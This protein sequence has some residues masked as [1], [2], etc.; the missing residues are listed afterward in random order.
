[1]PEIGAGTVAEAIPARW[2]QGRGPD[3]ESRMKPIRPKP[4]EVDSVM[5]PP[6]PRRAS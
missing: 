1:M 2:V 4:V 3:I 5:M 6:G